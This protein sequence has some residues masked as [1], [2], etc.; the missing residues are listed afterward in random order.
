MRPEPLWGGAVNPIKPSELISLQFKLASE[1]QNYDLWLDDLEFFTASTAQGSLSCTQPCPLE[2]VPFPETIVPETPNVPLVGGLT[3]H[4][5]DQPTVRCGAMRRRYLSFVPEGTT[6]SSNAP[7]VIVL[8]GSGCNAESMED[9]QTKGRFNEL[10]IRDGFIVAY[11]NAAPGALSSTDPGFYNTG[12]WRQD[13]FD[14][15]ELDDVEYL[16]LVLDDL[17]TRNVISGNNDVYLVGMSNGGGMVLKAATERPELWAGIAPFM[18]FDGWVPP[19][20]PNLIGTRLK[21][22]LFAISS[23]DPGLFNGT[24]SEVL[25]ALP[26]KWAAAMGLP[27]EAILS[28]VRSA[29]PNVVSEGESYTGNN[30]IAL[31]TRNSSVTQVDMSAAGATSQLRVL[32]IAHGGHFWPNPVGDSD[33]HFNE[34]YGFRNQDLDAADATWEYLSSS[35]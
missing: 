13:S 1:G 3:L 2:L 22:I 4:T 25:A 8:H 35:N 32:E 29:L 33:P 30:A 24:Y 10:A 12:S 9:F 27:T 14:D 7:V 17:K 15:G 26:A 16:S 20:V 19:P 18:A 6:Q 11:G 23:N 21:R 31:Q 5:F 28:P 34:T